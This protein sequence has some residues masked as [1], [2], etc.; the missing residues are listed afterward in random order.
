MAISEK[1]RNLGLKST[2]IFTL[3]DKVKEK[4][5]IL[6]KNTDL[7]TNKKGNARDVQLGR[8]YDLDG[9]NDYI[10]CGDHDDFSFGDGSQ[11]RPF[12]I[13]AWVNLASFIT[14]DI[15]TK[16]N[17]AA[18]R[19]WVFGLT[20]NIIA[21]TIYDPS[22]NKWTGRFGSINT[23]LQNTWVHITVTYDGIGGSTDVGA[24]G[25]KIYINGVRADTGNTG[26]GAVGVEY[27]AMENTIS[28]VR[29]GKGTTNYLNGKMFDVRIHSKELSAVEVDRVMF[30]GASSHEVGWWKFDEGSGVIA[31]D[32]SGRNHYG[33]IKNATLATLHV[34][35]SSLP[36]SFQNNYGFN[37]AKLYNSST[38]TSTT[39]TSTTTT[40]T[41][42][43]STSSSTTSSSTTS[44]SS[45]TT[46]SS[47]STSISTST[48]STTSLSTSSTSSTTTTV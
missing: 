12:S 39:S 30:G 5:V 41:S 18:I 45:S 35:D 43:T 7:F 26:G 21:F 48:T 31:Y 13:S 10:N 9:S 34:T 29:I 19:E 38:T 28:I 40:S 1:I 6:L 16:Q 36:Y 4:P 15:I 47:T 24:A 3:N 33:V 27:I 32:S 37:I 42:S 20:V 22:Q 17:T 8:C 44:T 2:R 46:S 23:S 11:D 25:I 14:Q